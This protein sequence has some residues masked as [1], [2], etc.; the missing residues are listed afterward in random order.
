MRNSRIGTTLAT[1][2]AAA[3]VALGGTL[4]AAPSASAAGTVGGSAC[5]KNIK[6][7]QMLVGSF[8][9]PAR[10]GPAGKYGE[11]T[12]LQSFDGFYVR[13]YKINSHHNKWFYG[14]LPR[15]SKRGWVYESYLQEL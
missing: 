15:S 4:V 6:N 14:D 10:K 7:H 13:C 2:T 1:V 5:S 12:R 3:A 9:A 8:G 11:I